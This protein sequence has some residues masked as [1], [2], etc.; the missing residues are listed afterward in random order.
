MMVSM[1]TNLLFP[2]DPSLGYREE[3]YGIKA[4]TRSRVTSLRPASH[5]LLVQTSNSGMRLCRQAAWE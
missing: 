1:V 3:K 5:C 4:V 2:Q